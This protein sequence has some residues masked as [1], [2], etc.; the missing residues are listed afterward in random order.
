MVLARAIA[1]AKPRAVSGPMSSAARSSG[2]VIAC[3]DPAGLRL[4]AGGR[5]DVAGQEHVDVAP[6]RPSSGTSARSASLSSSTSERPSLP[7][8]ALRNVL[9]IAPPMQQLRRRGSSRFSSTPI[10]SDT[11]APPMIAT[12]GRST[13][14]SSLLR[15]FTSRSISRPMPL[16]ATNLR[17]AHR[18]GVGAVRGAE[19]VV[20]VDV[21]VAGQGPR[22]GLVVGFLA[23]RKAQVLEQ[24]DR[25]GAQVV[26]DLL[27]RRRRPARRSA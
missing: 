5:H 6:P 3:D 1:S 13:S 9:A 19:R 15:N 25:A 8:L 21:G 23:G 16:S 14:P 26:D 7:P 10:L 22:E 11:L 27:A 18:R 20:D 12:N 2:T 24:R 17:D 4:D